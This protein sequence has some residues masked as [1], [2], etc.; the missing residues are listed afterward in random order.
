MSVPALSTLSGRRVGRNV[1][2]P[3]LRDYLR[4]GTLSQPKANITKSLINNHI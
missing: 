4:G 1:L 2:T 3:F